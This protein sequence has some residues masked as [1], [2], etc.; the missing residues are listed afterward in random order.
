MDAHDP[1]RSLDEL[2]EPGSTLMV[3]TTSPAGELEFRP[4]TVARAGASRIEILLDTDE[5]W[6]RSFR[7]GDPVVVTM[8]DNRTNTWLWLRGRATTANDE[9]RIDELWSPFAAAYFEDG[10]ATPGIA[11]LDIHPET[12]RYWTTTSGRLGA[13]VSALK[14]KVGRPDDAGAH[15]AIDV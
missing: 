1:P 15:G 2:L 7:D 13:L 12:G 14:A 6:V 3:G 5:A 8:G 4:L 11:I 10:R 9:A